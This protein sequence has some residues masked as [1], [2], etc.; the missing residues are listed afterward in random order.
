MATN[1]DDLDLDLDDADEA[2]PKS[3][4]KLFII[5]GVVVLLLG[6]SITA[7][8]IL[9]GAL[10]GDEEEVV[11]EQSKP[12]SK[13]EKNEKKEQKKSKAPLNYVP[14]DPPFVVNFTAD[15][16][17]RFLQITVEVGTRVLLRCRHQAS[18]LAR[19]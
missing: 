19:A 13:A 12:D 7:T 15:T 11:A 9:T 8:L 16:D 10:S 4:S 3:K 2:P 1:V 17:V 6:V 14:L 5:I 18:A